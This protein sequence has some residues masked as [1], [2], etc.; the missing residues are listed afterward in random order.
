[1][2]KS[3]LIGFIDADG[4]VYFDKRYGISVVGNKL[5]IS[6]FIE[7]LKRIGYDGDYKLYTNYSDVWDR[8]SINKKK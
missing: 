4:C 8:F 5:I 2:L 3:Y 7:S 6:W 1:M